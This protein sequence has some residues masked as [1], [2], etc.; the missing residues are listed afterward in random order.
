MPGGVAI[1][2]TDSQTSYVGTAAEDDATGSDVYPG[3]HIFKTTD[4]G[5]TIREVDDGFPHGAETA[6]H[7]IVVDPSAP[8]TVY[9]ATTTHGHWAATTALGVYKTTDGGLTWAPANDGL[10]TLEV[11]VLAIDPSDPDV[12]YAGTAD[13]VFKTDDG[14][15]TWTPIGLDGI[16]VHDLAVDPSDSNRIYA[17]SNAG[18]SKT[19]DGGNNWY[20]V[21]FG[22]CLTEARSLA[23]EP[24][25]DVLY[26]AVQGA[27]VFRAVINQ[28][29][30]VSVT[31]PANQRGLPGETL[32]YA[33]T[34]QNTGNVQDTFSLQAV[35]SNGWPA[36]IVDG[37]SIG[38]MD[39][40]LSTTFDIRMTIPA[41]AP[42]G[43]TDVLTLT[44]TSQLDPAASTSASVTTTV[45]IL[46]DLNCDPVK[47]GVMIPLT[48][49][50][51]QFGPYFQQATEL[52]QAHLGEAGYEI[53]LLFGDTETSA[54]PAVETARQLVE[55]EGVHVLVGATSS[56]VTIPIAESV[57][58]PNQVPQLSYASTS[59]LI[60]HLPADE[61]QDF[62]F[63]TV[64]SDALQGTVL[65][66]LARAHGYETVS[67]LYVNDP[68]GQGLNDVF[69]ENFEAQSGTVAASVPHDEAPA[70]TY[71][72]ELQQAAEGDPEALLALSYSAHAS[73]Y[74]DEALQG[75]FFDQ[76]LF[77]DG[78]KSQAIV[79]AVG[80]DALEGM[81]GTAPSSADTPSLETFNT[82]YEDTYGEPPPL[83]F[84]SNVYDAVVISALAA[85]E[86]QA[87]GDGLSP[88]SVRDH[89]RS[90]AGPGGEKVGAGPDELTQTIQLLSQGA[91]INYA[92]AAGAEDFDANGDVA[93]P[94]EVWCYA[95]GEI[96]SKHLVSPRSPCGLTGDVNSD[97][98]VNLSDIGL[99]A[100]TW[101]ARL[102]ELGYDL[103]YDLDN[104][105]VINIVDVQLVTIHVS[106]S[107]NASP[108]VVA[109]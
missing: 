94:V 95:G 64:P 9:L 63:R 88:V 60:T 28:V 83:P 54:V 37:P 45:C 1:D 40:S 61:G 23:L 82:T 72:A 36:D 49:P 80:A 16:S 74:V 12:L 27:G 108:S 107:C 53:E 29:A 10:T 75:G 55:A 44:A 77:V 81:C 52:A 85:Y 46:G 5:E 84:M 11:M 90:V 96:V 34:L 43:A 4:G 69:K 20:M 7:S 2:P 31:A 103:D 32:T 30:G 41:G 102:G 48:G 18:V 26:A 66:D 106:E 87:A 35:S 99:V 89:L 33:F 105:G 8:D 15:G 71:T 56:D 98:V 17:G 59:P 24:T 50:L 65:A 57:T 93:T 13:G 14:A 25:G 62:L 39:Y 38:P 6:I 73:A 86:A 91:S 100:G 76:F 67:A 3:A 78:T 58:I 19:N 47:L 70:S 92:G 101:R 68:Y 22:L 79:D 104:N 51:Q 109:Q 21:N 97:D 42:P